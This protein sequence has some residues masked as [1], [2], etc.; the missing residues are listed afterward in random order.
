MQQVLQEQI[1]VDFHYLLRQVLT[2]MPT[3]SSCG[4]EHF[5]EVLSG[6]K[7]HSYYLSVFNRM[8]AERPILFDD[9]VRGTLNV[10]EATKYLRKKGKLE[11]PVQAA[12]QFRRF[13]DALMQAACQKYAVHS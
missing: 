7:N 9:F 12:V 3:V 5:T 10:A 1:A 8:R 6:D 2:R 4:R 13:Y 11:V